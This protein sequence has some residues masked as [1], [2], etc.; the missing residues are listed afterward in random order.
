MTKLRHKDNICLQIVEVE[1]IENAYCMR[2]ISKLLFLLI[3]HKFTFFIDYDEQSNNLIW[4]N[5]M[6]K[7]AYDLVFHLLC[8]MGI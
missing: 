5:K 8:V 7:Y 2:M 6:N 3:Y 4:I 1:Q